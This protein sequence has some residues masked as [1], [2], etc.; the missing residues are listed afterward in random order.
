[1]VLRANRWVDREELTPGCEQEA[2]EEDDHRHLSPLRVLP[3]SNGSTSVD[4][5]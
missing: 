3:K 5:R 4:S 1:M 2:D